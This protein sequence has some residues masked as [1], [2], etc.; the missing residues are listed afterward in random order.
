MPREISTALRIIQT[1]RLRVLS[2]TASS[3]VGH[4]STGRSSLDSWAA[5]RGREA[6]MNR[7]RCVRLYWHRFSGLAASALGSG[8]SSTRLGDVA[9]LRELVLAR[10]ITPAAGVTGPW[11]A[12]L[13]FSSS[14]C[15]GLLNNLLRKHTAEQTQQPPHGVAMRFTCSGSIVQTQICTSSALAHE[16]LVAG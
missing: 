2:S 7:S 5:H 10:R 15:C 9:M 1:L 12:A 13:P 6:P 11:S 3:R 4:A 16:D 14:D 8:C